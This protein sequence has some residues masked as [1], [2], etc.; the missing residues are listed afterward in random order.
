MN[1]MDYGIK[2]NIRLLN[3]TGIKPQS[4]ELHFDSAYLF[5]I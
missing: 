2:F 1:T 3:K 4:L 5:Q